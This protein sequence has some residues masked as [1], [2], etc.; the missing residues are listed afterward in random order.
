MKKWLVLLLVLIIGL[1]I[2]WAVRK[3][4]PTFRPD[5]TMSL[6]QGYALEQ[7]EKTGNATLT[8]NGQA[9][10]GIL[11]C[12]Y[13]EKKWDPEDK[14]PIHSGNLCSYGD[15]IVAAMKAAGA[16]GTDGSFA[17]YMDN[18]PSYTD[19][20]LWFGKP[21]QEYQYYFYFFKDGFL[22]IWF[23]LNQIDKETARDLTANLTVPRL[24]LSAP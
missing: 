19:G 16:P 22:T 9:I 5:Y 3:S 24:F 21:E 23:D 18:G 17:R 4:R 15:T 10:G 6:P 7:D 14:L 12:P 2:F 13:V 8:Q 1:G 11:V 20:S